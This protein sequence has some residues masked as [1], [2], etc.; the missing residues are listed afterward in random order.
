MSMEFK[1]YCDT[2]LTIVVE[3]IPSCVVR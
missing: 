1:A 3:D 2:W